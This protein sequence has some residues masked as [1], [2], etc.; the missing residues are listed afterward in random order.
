MRAPLQETLGPKGKLIGFDR[1][2][3]AFAFATA[4]LNAL[5]EEL[6]SE[7]PVVEL[8][9]VEFSRA[10]EFLEP[11]SIDGLLADVGVSSMQL[12]E[13]HR[14]FSFQADGPLECGWIRARASTPNKW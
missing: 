12:D 4:K 3:E 8:H 11:G 10:A 2:P 5:R 7:M 14:G 1:D 13:A 9:D 6:G